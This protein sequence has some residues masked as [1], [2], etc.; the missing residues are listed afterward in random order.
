[1]K[2]IVLL[3]TAISSINMGDEIITTSIRRNWPELFEKNYIFKMASHSS[4]YKAFQI[5][6][7]KKYFR[8]I[9][10]SDYKFLCGTNALYTNM[11]RPKPNWNIGFG[12]VN[13]VKGTVC[14]GAGMGSNSKGV[15]LYTRKLYD[16]ALSKDYIHSTRDENTKV[17]LEKLGFKAVN[18]GCPTLWGLTPEHMKQ[19]P[20]KKT[21]RVIFTL[22]YYEKDAKRDLE[23]I[24]ILRK[25]YKELYFWPQCIRDLDYLQTL[26]DCSDIELVGPNLES[27]DKI[28]STDIDYV[29]NRLHGGIFALQHHCR[30]IIIAI[31]H[32][33]RDMGSSYSFKYIER[34]EIGKKLDDMINTEWESVI[35][36][37]DFDKIQEWKNQFTF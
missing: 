8:V 17:F 18:T 10:D 28:L 12:N 35:S 1:M 16:I 2:K 14:I 21:D 22:T 7:F 24:E 36:G 11:L 25:N 37:L 23:M 3:D 31:D 32:R 9:R 6:F 5:R 13:L 15:N 19:V 27:Y 29:G 26:T 33:V 20:H 4:M 34:S 30:S